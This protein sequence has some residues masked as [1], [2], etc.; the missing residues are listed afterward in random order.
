[1]TR[2]WLSLD[3][4]SLSTKKT[5]IAIEFQSLTE[6]YFQ[7]KTKTC[8]QAER[9]I[10]DE[11]TPSIFKTVYL[12]MIASS[13]DK[14]FISWK[15]VAYGQDFTFKNQTLMYEY[16]NGKHVSPTH[17][18]D[19]LMTQLTNSMAK[20]IASAVMKG[21]PVVKGMNV[22]FGVASDGF[23]QKNPYL[24]WFVLNNNHYNKKNFNTL[25]NKHNKL[26]IGKFS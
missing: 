7:R 14:S 19:E 26:C 1:M 21:Q 6:P 23:Y 8:L 24:T 10:D 13:N 5:R 2:F 15:P 9:S 3:N 22:S 17:K 20:G 4:L 11:Y 12:N 25:S 16:I 18:C